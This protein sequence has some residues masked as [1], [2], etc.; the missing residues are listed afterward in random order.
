V[1]AKTESQNMKP[2]TITID[3]MKRLLETIDN[4]RSNISCLI[5]EVE[6]GQITPKDA[7]RIINNAVADIQLASRP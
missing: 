7:A 6:R 2:T 5:A 1:P 3:R 4:Q